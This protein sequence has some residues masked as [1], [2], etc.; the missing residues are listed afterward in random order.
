MLCREDAKLCREKMPNLV[1][2]SIRYDINLADALLTP[3][4]V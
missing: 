3:V 1:C 2:N 4:A